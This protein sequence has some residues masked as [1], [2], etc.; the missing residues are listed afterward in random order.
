MTNIN[1][2]ANCSCQKLIYFGKLFQ[3]ESGGERQKEKKQD[4]AHAEDFLEL[5]NFYLLNGGDTVNKIAD[6]TP[7]N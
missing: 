5:K 4:V 1:R 7:K 2:T 3:S 6:V